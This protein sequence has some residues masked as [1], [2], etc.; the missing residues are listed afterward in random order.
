MCVLLYRFTLSSLSHKYFNVCTGNMLHYFLPNWN[1]SYCYSTFMLE[2]P[3]GDMTTLH[4]NI[5][6]HIAST[7][8]LSK[9]LRYWPFMCIA[10]VDLI[11][12]QNF[13]IPDASFKQSDLSTFYLSKNVIDKVS[14]HPFFIHF[15]LKRYLA[16]LL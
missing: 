7:T 9:A 6:S 4:M 2:N 8:I 14:N 11:R 10:F 13:H 3:R 16:P 15:S 1:F 5:P 12:E